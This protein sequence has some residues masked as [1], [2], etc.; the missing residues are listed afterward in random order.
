[1]AVQ[2]SDLPTLEI[3]ISRASDTTY[4]VE[5]R[6]GER[7]FPR[8][9]LGPEL[10]QPLGAG[11]RGA[12][13]FT[14]FTADEPIRMAWNLAAALHPTRRIRLRLDD[15]EPALHTLP[16]E[17][18]TDP[19]PIATARTL[20]ADRDTPFSRH[21]ATS[22]SVPGPLDCPPIKLLSAVA[23]PTDLDAYDLP[24]LDRAAEAA[25]IAEAVAAAPPNQVLHTHLAGP[26]TLAALEAELERGYHVLHLVAHGGL[27]RSDSSVATFLELPD[28]RTDRVDSARFTAMIE[29]LSPTLR[30]VVLMSCHSAARSP[31][32]ARAGLTPQLLAAGVPAVLAMQDL[33]PIDTA[34]AFT[35]AFYRELWLAGDIDRAANRAR[36]VVLTARLS[37]DAIP[38][39][40]SAHTSNRLWSADAPPSP[41]DAQKKPVASTTTTWKRL[42]GPLHSVQLARQRD[43]RLTL[44]GL[45]PQNNIKT[46]TQL[47]PGGAWGPWD[48]YGD[49]TTRLHLITDNR[50]RLCLF[51]L[52]GDGSPWFS[53]QTKLADAWDD[54]VSLGDEFTDLA[55]GAYSDNTLTV[56]GLDAAGVAHQLTR[57]PESGAWDSAWTECGGPLRQV[58]VLRSANGTLNV[59]A[60]DLD[61]NILHAFEADDD[62]EEW[63]DFY[64]FGGQ[65]RRLALL[66]AANGGL[67]LFAI[68]VDGGLRH[69]ERPRGEDWSD[70][71][72]LGG[73][74]LDLA[75]VESNGRLHV[76]TVG[77]DG[78]AWEIHQTD[79]GI[80][81]WTRLGGADLTHVF[82]ART[83]GAQIRLFALDRV[84]QLFTSG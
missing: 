59:F 33:V 67:H 65:A 17:A 74:H 45:G 55:A 75:P 47:A 51:T 50:G 68:G 46:T 11:D 69:C 49:N 40:Y 23:A 39:L 22:A 32:D 76:Y 3:R 28:G 70:W 2:R 1:M 18:L 77:S 54:W 41:P 37:G 43:G 4:S 8:G 5:L 79:D 42:A 52:D 56:L 27:R 15:L 80:S 14:R 31:T 84:G 82:A 25:C 26:C 7:E 48:D 81:D 58:V 64:E 35:L 44:F 38:V 34:H 6:I 16:W 62:N 72:D 21:V 53:A 83:V 57:S 63:V 20:A 9:T 13:L 36:A 29:R 12:Q 30:L 61:D 66:N 78:A 24:P 10:L 73:D 60:L 71:R 19:S